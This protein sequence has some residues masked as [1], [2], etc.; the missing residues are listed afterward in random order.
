MIVYN[1]GGDGV[2]KQSDVV[3]GSTYI[4]PVSLCPLVG[5]FHPFTFKVIINMYDSISIFLIV[6]G[7]FFCRCFPS[8][9]FP[10]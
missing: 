7:L 8:L 5:T 6:L 4:H 3:S 1:L 10:A 9:V 2:I